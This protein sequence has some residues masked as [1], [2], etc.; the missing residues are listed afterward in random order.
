MYKVIFSD[1]DGTLLTDDKKICEKNIQ[2][3]KTAQNKGVKFVVCT[4][5]LPFC[6]EMYA[7]QLDLSEAISTNGEIVYSNGKIISSS[8]LPKD[9]CKKVIEYGIANNE[10]E[11]IFSIDYLYL[12]N[13]NKGGSDANF[14]KQSKG[15]SND[16]ALELIDNIN[17]YKF[18]FFNDRDHLNKI[19]K[20]IE[21]MNLEADVVFSGPYLLEVVVKG[22]TKGVG[23]EEYCK[24]NKIDIKETI[25]VG[26]EENDKEML[27][28]VGL[29]C[30]PRNAS[31]LI[32]EICDFVT[33]NDNNEGS[34]AEIIENYV[35]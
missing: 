25:G 11:R 2:A 26:D 15:V 9:V 27:K 8:Y 5:R 10:Y 7:D 33:N 35:K 22:K 18:G 12:L 4:G 23:I 29:A 34:I 31:N 21:Q 14:Y 1:L 32:K 17:I 19:R 3:I 6:Y 20:N 16:E 28:T 24:Y 30:C 13:K